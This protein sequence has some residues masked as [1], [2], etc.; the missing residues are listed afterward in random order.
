MSATEVWGH[1]TTNGRSVIMSWRRAHFGTCDQI[2]ILSEFR[3]VAF[4]GR[5]LWWE[6]GSVSCQS[7]SAIIAHCKFFFLPF[8]KSYILCLAP[9]PHYKASVRTAQETPLPTFLVFCLCISFKG[10]VFFD[11]YLVM[12]ATSGASIKTFIREV[13]IY[14]LFLQINFSILANKEN[15]LRGTNGKWKFKWARG[16]LN[17]KR[18]Y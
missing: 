16:Y 3:C 14:S 2:L 11:L 9:G 10:D 18:E 15:T 5:P 4:V 13:T 1:V 17:M 7:L 6:V 8:Y 12:N